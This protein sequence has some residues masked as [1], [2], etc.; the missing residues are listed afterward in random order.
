MP[1][2]AAFV[3]EVANELDTRPGVRLEPRPDGVTVVRYRHAELGLLYPDRGLAELPFLSVE[4]DELIEHGQAEPALA[5][6]DSVGV[7]H[8][9]HGPSDVTKVVALFD[10]RYREVR[11]EDAPFSSEDSA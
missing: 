2:A 8:A 1:E 7:S 9:L 3:D 4:H 11:G 6:P 5:T 10:R